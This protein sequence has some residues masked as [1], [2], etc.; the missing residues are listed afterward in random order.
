MTRKPPV[1]DCED[2]LIYGRN[3][4]NQEAL[5]ELVTFVTTSPEVKA[6][7]AGYFASVNDV[8]NRSTTLLFRR[9]D[10][11]PDLVQAEADRLDVSASLASW[12][13]SMDELREASRRVVDAYGGSLATAVLPDGF[14]I[15]SITIW[16]GTFAG[17]TIHGG[18]PGD[19]VRLP[20]VAV[21]AEV[22]RIAGMP[23][24][25]HRSG[26]PSIF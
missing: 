26:R 17:L 2:G 22:Q 6:S 25:F 8:P 9:P 11:V 15:Y 14:E 4:A 5:G 23:I 18:H 1:G 21:A 24:R 13:Y 7:G 20:N 16:D 19:N 10:R 12:P 3:D